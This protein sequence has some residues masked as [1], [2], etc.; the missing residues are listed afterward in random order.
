M[1]HRRFGR[2]GHPGH[3]LTRAGQAAARSCTEKVSCASSPFAACLTFTPSNRT[4]THTHSHTHTH[5]CGKRR[6]SSFPMK[7]LLAARK[8]SSCSK[9]PTLFFVLTLLAKTR[10]E[11][12][13]GRLSFFS[14]KKK[15]F[16]FSFTEELYQRLHL[17]CFT[18]SPSSFFII[19][20]LLTFDK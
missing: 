17:F 2:L 8:R 9:R 3:E 14:K 15:G 6:K 11:K 12:H 1:R 7:L 13:L 18:T 20:P 19:F 4:Q 16:F 10:Q 5:I